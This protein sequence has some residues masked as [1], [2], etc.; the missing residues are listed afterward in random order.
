M[1]KIILTVMI[2]QGFLYASFY[3]PPDPDAFFNSQGGK[4]L[5]LQM[6][7]KSRGDIME[8]RNGSL[9]QNVQ[10][11]QTTNGALNI[12]Y[13]WATLLYKIETIKIPDSI[14]FYAMMRAS[15]AEP[16]K[17]FNQTVEGKKISNQ[18]RAAVGNALIE[19]HDKVSE[20]L[21]NKSSD[22][23]YSTAIIEA[24]IDLGR[25]DVVADLVAY[26]E[27]PN[28]YK[29]MFKKKHLEYVRI[30]GFEPE[31]EGRHHNGENL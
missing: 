16:L 15:N 19:Y 28:G 17:V 12:N 24:I 3:T 22:Y 11:L 18:Q 30:F 1:K 2:L 29:S 27:N 9:S 14:L 8:A 31:R 23:E 6:Y 20:S 7:T 4:L 26:Y 10:S 25:W 21:I 5:T 13:K